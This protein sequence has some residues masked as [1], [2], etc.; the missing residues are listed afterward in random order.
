MCK[1]LTDTG[2]YLQNDIDL[3]II[4]VHSTH[5]WDLWEKDHTLSNNKNYKA[6]TYPIVEEDKMIPKTENVSS[7]QND[8]FIDMYEKDNNFRLLSRTYKAFS[9][10]EKGQ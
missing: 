2:M 4:L 9:V 7:D 8:N 6:A 1:V 10:T 5:Q 3:I